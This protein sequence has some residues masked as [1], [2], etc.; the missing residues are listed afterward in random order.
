MAGS[1]IVDTVP[2]QRRATLLAAG[3]L[4]Q[5]TI[6]IVLLVTLLAF[7]N[8]AV[9]TAMPRA[10]ASLHALA[11]YGWPFTANLLANL[12]G[13]VVG[14]RLADRRGP[15]LPVVGGIALFAVGLV[16]AGSS[17]TM[18][19]FVLGRAVQG[20]GAGLVIVAAYVLVAA[21]YP[22]HLRPKAF[23][24][25]SAAW[26]VPSLVGPTISGV[27]TQ[28]VTWRLVF[29]GIVPFAIVG[30]LLVLPTLRR[31]PGTETS[32]EARR[33][34]WWAAV[35]AGAGVACLQ[36]AGQRLQ[37]LSLLPLAAGLAL[38][39]VGVPRL[40]PRGTLRLRRGLPTVILLRGIVSGAYFA[41]DSAV[42]LTLTRLHGF[43]PTTAGLPLMLGSIGWSAASWWQGRQ[44]SER[45]RQGM[46]IG[47]LLIAVA[48]LGMA[49]LALPT[50]PGW[51]AYPLWIVGGAGIGAA[52]PV[53]SVL[54]LGL[55]PVAERGANSSS[56][57]VADQ[58]MSAITIAGQGTLVAAAAAGLL[59]LPMAIG[60]LDLAMA[61]LAIVGALL[62]ARITTR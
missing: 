9:A 15:A 47:Y 6:G 39:V 48:S 37:L 40:L 16:L 60:T 54:T 55:S 21:A 29:F 13:N 20:A 28:Y 35:V 41:V 11:F 62:V 53:L 14:G 24:A 34:P 7:E 59:T 33:V 18:A 4:R 57:Q 1:P 12:V 2:A 19:Q 23:S 56:L 5:A 46:R 25:M 31:L 43:T 51:L 22:E 42:P 52:M 26:V 58:G 17:T 44:G 61:A 50:T 10:V 38:L 8:M 32:A 45:R 36:V 3:P 49:S 30:L 27:A